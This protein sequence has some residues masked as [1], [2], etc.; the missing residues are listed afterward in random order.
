MVGARAVGYRLFLV[1]PTVAL[2]HVNHHFRLQE[3]LDP[4]LARPP[5][6]RGLKV[7]LRGYV[8]RYRGR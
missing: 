3:S 5:R 1:E 2:L 6:R 4:R 8:V 7:D